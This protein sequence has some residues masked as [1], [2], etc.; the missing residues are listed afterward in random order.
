MHI[1][2]DSTCD[3]PP[4]LI[5]RYDLRLVPIFITLDGVPYRDGVDLSTEVF[6]QRLPDLRTIPTTA[7][8]AAPALEAIF[9]QFPGEDLVCLFLTRKF[10]SLY[11]AA[12]QLAADPQMAQGR[13]IAVVETG[14]LSLGIGW[15]VLAAAEAAAAGKPLAEVLA[16]VAGVQQRLKVYALLDTL[17]YVRHGGR[18]SAFAAAVG[19][20]LQI[21]VDVELVDGEVKPVFKLRTRRQAIDKLVALTQALGPLERLAILHAHRLEEAQALAERLAACA[22]PPPLMVEVSGVVTAHVGPNALGVAVVKAA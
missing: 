19:N 13:K 6:Y 7:A 10:S 22:A 2:T 5:A 20:L 21:K 9:R 15:Q 17:D 3:L 12:R 18:V 16:A 8:P 14:Q 4:A 1:I 11:E